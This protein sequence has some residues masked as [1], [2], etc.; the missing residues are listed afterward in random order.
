MFHLEIGLI[1]GFEQASI[2]EVMIKWNGKVEVHDG[3]D[4]GGV[5]GRE[6]E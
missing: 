1:Q 2:I 5:F 3:G 4:K 6:G